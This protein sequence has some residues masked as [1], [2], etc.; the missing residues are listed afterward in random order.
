MPKPRAAYFNRHGLIWSYS[1]HRILEYNPLAEIDV[2]LVSVAGSLGLAVVGYLLNGW[3]DR[4][5]ERRKTNYHAKLAA[6]REINVAIQG[7]S[8]AYLYLSWV[9]GVDWDREKRDDKLGIALTLVAL[10]R[11]EEARL[12]TKVSQSLAEE[13]EKV[14]AESDERRQRAVADRWLEGT[15]P[16]LLFL[17]L[18]L[19]VF[20]LNSLGKASSDA[21]LV[22]E[23][24][25]VQNA[26][27]ALVQHVGD[28]LRSVEA[29]TNLKKPKL[30][31]IEAIRKELSPL[32][33]KLQMT[34]REDL[35]L[36]M[37]STWGRR[38]MIRNAK[39]AHA[40]SVGGGES[41]T[42]TS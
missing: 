30:P 41:Q 22:A 19:L 42:D 6:F 28:Q 34:M 18:R 2:V 13:F 25:A 26:I 5:F 20:N 21:L 32:V 9:S 7:L 24:P 15:I 14:A 12:G 11:E 27:G 36:T 23:T 35:L 17:W 40:A 39:R 10:A 1:C 38:R 31:D 37:L 16:S 8:N 3:R 4:S 29:T 33:W